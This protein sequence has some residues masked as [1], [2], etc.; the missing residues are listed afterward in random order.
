MITNDHERG[1]IKKYPEGISL[2]LT[3][4]AGNTINTAFASVNSDE[5]YFLTMCLMIPFEPFVI[6]RLVEKLHPLE[7][8]CIPIY[9]GINVGSAPI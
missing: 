5:Q 3:K 2:H 6:F 4:L 8:P 9:R 1:S 7:L